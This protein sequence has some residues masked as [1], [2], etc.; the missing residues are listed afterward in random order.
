MLA[1]KEVRSRMQRLVAEILEIDVAQVQA[2]SRLR[3]DL[4]MD[5]LGSLELLSSISEELGIH[6]DIDDAMGIVTF[7]D[8][9]VFV[10]RSMQVREAGASVRA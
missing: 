9:C 6:L 3:E 10:E 8:A 4:G 7:H 5:S 1:E 2:E